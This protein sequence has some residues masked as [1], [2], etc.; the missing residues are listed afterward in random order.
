MK[1]ER[2]I[3]Y[4]AKAM[5]SLSLILAVAKE[6]READAAMKPALMKALQHFLNPPLMA[7]EVPDAPVAV[8]QTT[9]DMPRTIVE[10]FR[11]AV[12][13]ERMPEIPA[14]QRRS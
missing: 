7:R 10:P 8:T 5:D 9:A 4:D 12:A 1:L 3:D 11:E 14:A 13:M 6:Y 2:V